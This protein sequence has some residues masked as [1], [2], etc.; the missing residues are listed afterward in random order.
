MK[1][2]IISHACMYIEGDGGSL[3]VD[4][5][6]I[7]SCYWR[8]WWNFPEPDRS[9]IDSLKPDYI[10]ITHLHWDHFQ[11]PSLRLFDSNTRVLT[12]LCPTTRMVRDLKSLKM[13]NVEEV[14][15]GGKV[16]LWP[17]TFLH[18]YQFGP[19]FTDSAIVVTDGTTTIFDSNDCKFFGSPLQQIKKDFPSIDFCLRSHS[20]ANPLP[21]C[22]DNYKEKFPEVRTKQD[23]IDEFTNFN[24]Y[25]G[26]RYAV[27]FASNHCFLHKET[28]HFN[29]TAVDPGM[30]A[31]H[32]NER[33]GQLNID[34]ECVVMAP[35][36]SWCAKEGFKIQ[37]F[38]YSQKSAYVAKLL[39]KYEAKL[40]RQYE[41]EAKT[42]ANFRAFERYFG[43]LIKAVPNI[44]LKLVFP[45]VIFKAVESDGYRYFLVDFSKQDIR[46]L[47]QAEEVDFV[48]EVPALVL[49]DCTR[50][51]MFSSWSPSKRLK[52]HMQGNSLLKIGLFLEIV[53]YYENEGFPLRNNFSKRQFGVRMRR[54]REI[55]ES[56]VTVVKYKILGRQFVVSKLY[57]IEKSPRRKTM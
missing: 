52:I 18:S 15:H 37:E 54:W 34:S 5:W 3:L 19:F 1:F 11:G 33:A 4:P 7:G 9:L 47:E 2:T 40:T 13:R 44:V 26:S 51:F 42:K 43:K 31:R 8:S 41:L 23:Y 25:I 6:L 20:S 36:S 27:P 35:G 21:Y 10:Y 28:I 22:I 30:V 48:I 29:D 56:I 50:K 53:D 39:E 24:F 38:D 49:N 46:E 16:E 32:Y 17:G 57:P 12:P 14:P 55:V 45:R